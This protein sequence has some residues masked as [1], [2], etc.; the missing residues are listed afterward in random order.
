LAYFLTVRRGEGRGMGWLIGI[1]PIVVGRDVTCTISLEDPI[2][3]RHHCRIIL[4]NAQPK[5]EDMGSR[6][7]TFLNGTPVKESA[8]DAGDEIAVGSTIFCIINAPE[9]ESSMPAAPRRT[10]DTSATA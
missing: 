1:V 8:L 3:S 4:E 7:A 2:V 9:Q 10:T 6:N 5:V